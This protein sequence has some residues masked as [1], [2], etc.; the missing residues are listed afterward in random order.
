MP[1]EL[2]DPDG[3]AVEAVSTFFAELQA[4]GRA[5]RRC[6]LMDGPVAMVPLPM[7]LGVHG[8]GRR[9]MRH[10]TQPL[11]A[12]CWQ[13]LGRTGAGATRYP[14]LPVEDPSLRSLGEGPQRDCPK[15]LLRVPPRDRHGPIMS[16]F[17]LDRSRR[18]GG[19]TPITTRWSLRDRAVGRY[20]P[21]VPARVPGR[22]R[23]GLQRDL[24]RLCSNRDGRSSPFTSHRR[25]SLRAVV[26][27]P[28]GSTPAAS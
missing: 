9:G 5:M 19:R 2:V 25:E 12:S 4:A 27:D 6:A 15:D 1:N 18:A 23:R 26:F 24:R 21:K 28:R 20:R 10:A 14:G 16:P 17:P 7:G 13:A 11:V 22:S 8:T 3:V